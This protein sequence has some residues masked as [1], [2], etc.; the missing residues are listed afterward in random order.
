MPRKF[1]RRLSVAYREKHATQ[2]WYLRPFGALL[3]HP[4][5]FSINRRSISSAMAIALFV[6]VLPMPGHT[7]LALVLGLLLRA[8]LPV[9]LLVIWVA[10]PLTYAPILYVEYQLGTYLL[11]LTPQDF[12]MDSSWG[13]LLELLGKAW[14]PLWFGAIVGGLLLAILGYG[15]TNA[16][17]R[18]NTLW[19]YRRRKA[20]RDTL[21]GH[22]RR[23]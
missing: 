15:M 20:Q 9:A 3:S 22:D 18:A 5:Y 11:G 1:L 16:A 23:S 8:N 19:R 10:N 14:R 12:S 7:P 2:P 6:A 17:W 21:G 13:E 4:V